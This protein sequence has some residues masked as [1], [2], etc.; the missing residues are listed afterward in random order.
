M[1][2]T[3]KLDMLTCKWENISQTPLIPKLANQF[4]FDPRF[5][6]LDYPLDS[7]AKNEQSK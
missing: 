6:I 4:N 1:E 3:S 2:M 5:A 7:L